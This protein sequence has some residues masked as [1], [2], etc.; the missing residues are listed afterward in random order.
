LLADNPTLTPAALANRLT[1]YAV[2]AGPVGQDGVYGAGIVNAYNSLMQTHGST[3]ALFAI[4]YDYNTGIR[5]D[6]QALDASGDYRFVGVPNGEFYVFAGADENGDGLVGLP[7]RPWSAYGSRTLVSGANNYF[8]GNVSLEYPVGAPLVVDG[9]V[10]GRFDQFSGAF[11][12]H[13]QIPTIGTYT[14]ETSA[15]D[16]TCGLAIESDTQ[17]LLGQGFTVL[18]SNDDVSPTNRCSRITIALTPGTYQVVVSGTSGRFRL[19][20]RSGT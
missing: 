16:G 11:S 3:H 8:G 18:G 20:A 12:Y 5:V 15:I 19:Q 1:E 13:L 6:A 14:F 9:Y 2:D 7:G 10:M 17:L 4:L